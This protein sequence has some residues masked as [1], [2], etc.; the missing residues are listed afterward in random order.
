MHAIE[1]LELAMEVAKRLGYQIRQ[2]YL[3]GSGGGACEFAGKRWI[4]VDLAL[5]TVEQIEQVLEALEADPELAQTKLPAP[6]T[7]L[8]TARRAA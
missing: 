2:E 3:G 5:N 1:V 7:R 6:L 4:F 8:F